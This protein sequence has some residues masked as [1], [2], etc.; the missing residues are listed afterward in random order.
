MSLLRTL[1]LPIQFNLS[2]V[3]RSVDLEA[4]DRP[5]HSEKDNLLDICQSSY[6]Q[7]TAIIA[8]KRHLRSYLDP[9]SLLAA[10]NHLLQQGVNASCLPV[11]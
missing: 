6:V 5:G 10:I 11:F 7:R 2:E 8:S 3:N 1:N 4:L 9:S